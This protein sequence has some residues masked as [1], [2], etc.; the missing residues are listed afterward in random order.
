MRFVGGYD[1]S[2]NWTSVTD[3]Y[4][5]KIIK[6]LLLLIIVPLGT[7]ETMEFVS[8]GVLFIPLIILSYVIHQ[9]TNNK[10]TGCILKN[11]GEHAVTMNGG[12]RSK[13][14]PSDHIV[15][16]SDISCIHPSFF[17]LF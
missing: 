13:L 7:L 9:G 6:F 5:F 12:D 11:A 10:V 16:N 3:S 17:L 8:V 1:I 4:P 15:N 14:I 2:A